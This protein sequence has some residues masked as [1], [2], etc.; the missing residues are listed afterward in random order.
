MDLQTILMDICYVVITGCGVIIG[1]FLVDLFDKWINNIQL[2]TELKEYDKLNEYIDI[3][4]AAI[5]KAV[6][7]TSQVYVESLKASGK[8]D[9][10]AQIEAKNKALEIAR[11]LITEES[12]NAI[13]ILYG[14]FEKFLDST[15]ESV[16][17][18]NK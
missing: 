17:N 12:K 2:S 7:S 1:K 9:K 4:Q 10:E 3:A 11:Q 13:I 8:F 6:I 16:V 14:D 15:L 18:M 5:E